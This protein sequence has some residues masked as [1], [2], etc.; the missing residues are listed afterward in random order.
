[1]KQLLEYQSE[2]IIPTK[3]EVSDAILK[4]KLENCIIKLH[5]RGVFR[6]GDIVIDANSDVKDCLEKIREQQSPKYW[7]LEGD[8][9]TEFMFF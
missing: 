1:M 4:A 6:S 8:S 3:E 2:D 7:S 9:K 5:Y